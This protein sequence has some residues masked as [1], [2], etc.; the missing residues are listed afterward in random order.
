MLTKT[1]ATRRFA[2]AMNA[3]ARLTASMRAC[4]A[5]AAVEEHDKILDMACG[6]GALLVRLNDQYR[7]TVCGMCDTP[8]QA[9][10]ARDRLGDADVVPGRM[11]DIPWR[12]GSFHVVLLSAP[13]RGDVKRIL[14]ETLRVMHAG[15]Q[16]VL[17][18][19][20]LHPRGEGEL[21]KREIMR[22][23]QEAGFEEV[24]FRT[25]GLAGVIIGWKQGEG[26]AAQ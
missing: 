2:F 6:Q 1:Q 4:A 21:G 24:S 26:K 10:V 15:G 3:E 7:V 11:E 19:P 8:E 18:V 16:F 20:L 23:M 14:D 25:A 5:W 13:L 17:S 12:D 22:L 9:R